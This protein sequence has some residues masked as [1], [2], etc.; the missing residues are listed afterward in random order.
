MEENCHEFALLLKSALEPEIK[1]LEIYEQ[2]NVRTKV[3]LRGKQFTNDDIVLIESIC[4]IGNLKCTFKNI[5]HYSSYL[6]DNN[7]YDSFLK[8]NNLKKKF[9]KSSHINGYKTI[10]YSLKKDN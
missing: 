9:V 2:I 8:E 4:N 6:K 10:E 3:L 7:F 1:C 5:D